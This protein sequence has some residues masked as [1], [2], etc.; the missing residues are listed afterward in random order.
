MRPLQLTPDVENHLSDVVRDMAPENFR[1][2]LE[3]GLDLPNGE[4]PHWE[5]VKRLT[6]PT[7]LQPLEYWLAIKSARLR[8]QRR[9]PLKQKSGAPFFF[10]EPSV[11]RALLSELDLN[12]GGSVSLRGENLNQADQ[13]RYL[14]RSLFEEPFSSS[15][16]EGAATTRQVA[17]K[18]IEEDRAPRTRDERMILNNFLAMRYVK[19]IKDQDLTPDIVINIHRIVTEGTLD[20]P[21]Q[22]GR[23]RLN[24]E[25]VTVSDDTTGEILHLPPAAEELQSR[26]EALCQFANEPIDRTNF[27]HP[28]IKAIILH[29]MLGYDHPFADGNGRTARAL[30]YWYVV[31]SKYWIL[32][33][34]SI[35]KVIMGAPIQYGNAFLY[36][37]S[38]HGDLTYFIIHQ[39][40]V[41]EKSINE[42]HEH[43]AETKRKIREFSKALNSEELNHRQSF[44]LN[45]A[46]RGRLRAIEIV[47]HQKNQKVS[48]L[49]ARNDLEGLVDSGYFVKSKSGRKSIYRPKANLIERLTAEK[50]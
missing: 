36:T 11:V 21:D 1:K 39:L 30:F 49:T 6:P 45:D 17:K 4:Y 15:V 38:D 16:L 8:A 5:R 41:I 50:K 42:L 9:V 29:F 35:S 47:T 27:V 31:K 19:E 23:L 14:A 37:E 2:W 20:N 48:Y 12:A 43:L 44:I 26:L 3:I 18:M 32:E 33:Y 22:C 13:D 40:K 28:I 10:T 34:I 24:N 7:G 25:S 46:A